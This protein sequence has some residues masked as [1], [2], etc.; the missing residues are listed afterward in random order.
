[1]NPILF[2]ILVVLTTSLMGSSFALGKIGLVYVSPL[3]L[4]GLRFTIAGV[5]MAFIFIKKPLP[6]SWADWGRIFLVGL[7]QTA[8]VMGCIFVSLRTITA[9]ESSILTFSNP[10]LVV[11]LGTIFLGAKY[12]IF[13]WAGVI[14]GF[15]GVFI[16]LGFH[17][18]LEQGTILGLGAALSWA[19][20]T[21]LIKKWGSRF[22]IWVLTAYQM[23][24]GGLLLLLMAVTIETPK[25]TINGTSVFIIL[26]LAIMAS[27]IQ[28]MIWFYLLNEGDP[29]K[30]SAFLFLAP[31]FGVLS[32]WLLLGEVL[33]WYV[34]IGGGLIF[35]S[36]FL[37][38]WTSDKKKQVIKI[39]E[40][41]LSKR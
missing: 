13:H 6:K 32:G 19:I 39:N 25:L 11:I 34:F 18:Q 31:F 27:I 33:K 30:T 38:N 1:M 15:I 12:G 14:I 4:V 24:F 20:A 5:L 7:F 10:L 41:V 40:Q 23:L 26:W 17:L 37:V 22:N 8:G 29:G 21:L 2:G 35:I 9:G 3:L 28:F 36:I 16:T